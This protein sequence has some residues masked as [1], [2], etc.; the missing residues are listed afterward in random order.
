[1]PNSSLD[2]VTITNTGGVTVTGDAAKGNRMNITEKHWKSSAERRAGHKV[3]V[4]PWI[5][6]VHDVRLFQTA[7]GEWM[8]VNGDSNPMPA[9]DYEVSLWLQAEESRQNLAEAKAVS[10][11]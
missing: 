2:A 7:E 10:G 11:D 5:A 4:A 1:L 9:T 3:I 8:I 6:R